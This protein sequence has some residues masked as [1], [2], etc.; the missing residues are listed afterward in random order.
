MERKQSFF[1]IDFEKV[2]QEKQAHIERSLF[3][4]YTHFFE[5][6]EQHTNIR[7]KVRAKKLFSHKTKIDIL[8]IETDN[9]IGAHFEHWFAFDYITVVGSRMFDLFVREK[10]GD[11]TKSMLDLS[12]FFM[13]MSLEPVQI[14]E[15]T[16]STVVYNS[17]F[18]STSDTAKFFL[19]SPEVT[20]GDLVFMRVL[21]V[22][23]VKKV[24]GPAFSIMKQRESEVLQEVMLLKQSKNYRTKMKENGIDYLR[25]KKGKDKNT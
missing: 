18:S 21:N 12:G 10:K 6:M 14:D 24:I 16:G 7:E 9:V 19:F 13:L 22:G 5:Y 17:Y 3:D 8:D 11:L 15:V 20:A 25:Y 23:S 2:K 1:L 4:L